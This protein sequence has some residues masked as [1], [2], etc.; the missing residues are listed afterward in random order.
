M[1]MAF[2]RYR[3]PVKNEN[4]SR[5]AV[6]Q[7]SVGGARRVAAH[8][9]LRLSVHVE[10]RLAA[11]FLLR[12]EGEARRRVRRHRLAAA[13]SATNGKVPLSRAGV[14][15][16]T[17][18][19]CLGHSR[20]DIV[21]RYDRH[22]YT[23]RNARRL[24]GVGGDDRDH[25]QPAGGRSRRHGGRAQQAAALSMPRDLD[26]ILAGGADRSAKDNLRCFGPR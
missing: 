25:H 8:R 16:D 21:E 17:A 20:G 3:R 1:A 11:H 22:S 5:P 2:G 13:R 18:E 24:R 6:V 14:H 19:K 12:P 9:R 7:G 23:R 26:A 15:S 4:R 10:R